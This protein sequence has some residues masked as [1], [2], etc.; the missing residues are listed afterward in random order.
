MLLFSANRLSVDFEQA[1]GFRQALCQNVVQQPAN[2]NLL[3]LLAKPLPQGPGSYAVSNLTFVEH[4]SRVV[5][6]RVC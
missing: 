5:D 6:A 2:H 1:E 3:A 4:R